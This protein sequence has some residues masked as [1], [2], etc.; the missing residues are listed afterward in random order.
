M[1]AT[2]TDTPAHSLGWMKETRQSLKETIAR[3]I[4]CVHI[5]LT[6]FTLFLRNPIYQHCPFLSGHLTGYDRVEHNRKHQA[7][8][9]SYRCRYIH[10]IVE[11]T[12]SLTGHEFKAR[13]RETQ[14]CRQRNVLAEWV[15]SE[16]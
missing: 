5:Y 2:E 1:C 6:D 15:V 7:S 4:P 10:L 8:S 12:K 9:E 3:C 13:Q 14:T 16:W 11:A